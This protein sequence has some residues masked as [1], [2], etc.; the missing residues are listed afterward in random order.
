MSDFSANIVTAQQ[1]GRLSTALSGVFGFLDPTQGAVTTSSGLTLNVAAIAANTY[2][3]NSA[4]Q[5]NAYSASTVTHDAAHA[6]LDRIDTIKINTSGAVGIEKGTAASD[7]VPPDLAITE[8]EVAQILVGG[9]VSE[10]TSGNITDRRQAVTIV[11]AAGVEGPLYP[12][13]IEGPGLTNR[14][15]NSNTSA[16][17]GLIEINH[18]KVWNTMSLHVTIVGGAGVL[19]WG[20]FS[21]DGQTRLMSESTASISGTGLHS[22]AVATPVLVPPGL[23]YLVVVPVGSAD[24]TVVMWDQDGT[25]PMQFAA[26]AGENEASGALTVSAGTIPATFDPDGDVTYA[27]NHTLKLRID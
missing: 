10:I 7:P 14:Q 25:G 27:A 19:A 22:D 4:V 15:L 9:G 18:P 26:P 12:R 13:A 1:L 11:S 3:I 24:L 17:V 21:N 16:S 6:S 20:L 2:V 5:A 23:Y 8:L